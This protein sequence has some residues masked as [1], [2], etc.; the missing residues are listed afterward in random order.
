MN[1]VATSPRPFAEHAPDD[2]ARALRDA[3]GDA[4]VV[5][6]A[7][8]RGGRSGALLLTFVVAGDAWVLRRPDP[9]RPMHRERADRQI[10][11]MR[12]ASE[13][14][15]SPPL[16]HVDVASG[17]TIEAKVEG[18]PLRRSALESGRIDQLAGMLRR[19]HYGPPFPPALDVA[20]I[21]RHF[22]QEIRRRGAPGLPESILQTL[23]DVSL[24]T[25]R[26][27]ES[28]PCHNDLNPGN[29]L[30]TGER[31]YLVDWETACAGDPFVDLGQL[32]VFTFVTPESRLDLLERYLGRTP[33]PLDRARHTLAHALA[34]AF[35][36]AGFHFASIASGA[37]PGIAAP[38]PIP[39]LLAKLGRGAAS[40]D[41]V[42]SS[43]LHEMRATIES[44]AYAA[45][46]RL[47]G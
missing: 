39:E 46:R 10:A 31:I 30:D 37:T 24:A 20:A 14:G 45:S 32:G 6:I 13:R 38:L 25:R 12:I 2:V 40:S 21:A 44:D 27:A 18:T 1:A 34:L 22:D 36:A 28:A 26:F 19:L 3:F 9:T 16:R 43:L 42:A 11:C 41:V 35:Y 23:S 29:F 33:T 15:L 5:D 7:P 17:I 47:V 4:R 8:L